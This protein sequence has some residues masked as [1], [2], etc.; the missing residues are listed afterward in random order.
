MILIRYEVERVKIPHHI[1]YKTGLWWANTMA[2][3]AGSELL[4]HDF[5][6]I[7][8]N[9]ETVAIMFQL[10]V[11]ITGTLFNVDLLAF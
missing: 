1:Y 11:L 2:G 8:P 3:H 5:D 6:V 10:I 4:G 7:A 9:V